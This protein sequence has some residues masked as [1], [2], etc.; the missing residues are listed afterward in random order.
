[1]LQIPQ[2]E[3]CPCSFNL[4]P[5]CFLRLQNRSEICLQ[6]GKATEDSFKNKIIEIF[7]RQNEFAQ[8]LVQEAELESHHLTCVL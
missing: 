3:I 1:M 5:M 7:A 8:M 4:D 6:Y 2:R